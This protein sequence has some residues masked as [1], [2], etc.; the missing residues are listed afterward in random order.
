MIEA[1]RETQTETRW[2]ADAFMVL[3]E[4]LGLQSF[5]HAVNALSVSNAWEARARDG[6]RDDIDRA[7][8]R[9]INAIAQFEGDAVDQRIKVWMSKQPEAIKQWNEILMA[10]VEGDSQS[11]PLMAVAGR[12]LAQLAMT[13]NNT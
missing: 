10:A 3:G 6:L 12:S 2:A 13:A 5:A 11:Y 8:L 1:A 9:L 4:S 7:Y